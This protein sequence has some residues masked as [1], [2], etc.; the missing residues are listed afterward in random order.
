[1]QNLPGPPPPANSELLAALGN[2]QVE[3]LPTRFEVELEFVQ[4]LANPQYANFLAQNNYLEDERF[5]NYLEYLEYWR[6]PEYVKYLIYPNCLHVLTLL[7]QPLFRRE[8]RHADMAQM[9]MNDMYA[10]WLGVGNYTLLQ[11]EEAIHA[12]KENAGDIDQE[13]A[14]IANGGSAD[15]MEG[16]ERNGLVKSEST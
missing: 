8:L 5:I 4:A 11:N 14:S 6:K 13:S 7:K 9:L 2:S 12:D 3:P 1:M 16:V 15:K 10:K